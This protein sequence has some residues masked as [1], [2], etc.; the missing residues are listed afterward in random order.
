MNRK[1][2]QV[3]LDAVF[4]KLITLKLK[5]TKIYRVFEHE[6]ASDLKMSQ[7]CLHGPTMFQKFRSSCTCTNKYPRFQVTKKCHK[8]FEQV[9]ERPTYYT[10]L[11]NSLNNG[12]L[13]LDMDASYIIKTVLLQIHNNKEHILANR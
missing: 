13:I 5:S 7:K 10:I 6:I 9:K 11:Y 4:N 3:Y 8:A 2:F 1:H 12:D